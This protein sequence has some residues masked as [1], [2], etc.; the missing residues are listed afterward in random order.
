MKRII[1]FILVLALSCLA[2]ASCELLPEEVLDKLEELGLVSDDTQEPAVDT[3]PAEKPE[4]K[5]EEKPHEHDFVLTAKEDGA[6]CKKKGKE[7]YECS[8]GETKTVTTAAGPHSFM[9]TGDK[10]PSCL[11]QGQRTELCTT[12]GTTNIERYGE[13]TGH[14]VAEFEEYSRMMPCTNAGCSYAIFPEGNGKYSEVIVYK[15]EQV[16]ESIAS[17]AAIYAE[18]DAM[19]KAADKYDPA[20]HAFVQ[21][22]ELYYANQAMEAKYEELYDILVFITGQYQIGQLEYYINLDSASQAN[23]NYVSSARTEMVSKFYSFNGPIAESMFREYYFYGMS[24]EEIDAYVG[25]SDA[26]SNPEYTALV[27]RNDEI[28]SEYL[29]LTDPASSNEVPAMYAEFVANNKRIAEILGY[30]NYLEYAYKEMYSRDYSYTDVKTVYNYVKTYVSPVYNKLYYNFYYYGAYNEVYG[31]G[32]FFEVYDQNKSLNDYIDLLTISGKNTAS[33]S[34]EFNGLMGDG[35]CFR[36][37]KAGTA[38]VTSLYGVDFDG[39]DLP[40]AYFSKGYDNF[41]TI[42]HEFGHYMNE[43]YSEGMYSQSYDLLEMHS[44]GNEMLFLA[45]LNNNP[46]AISSVGLQFLNDYQPLNMFFAIM[47]AIAVDAFEQAVYTDYYDG[48][49]YEAIMDYDATTGLYINADEYDDLFVCILNDLGVD[50]QWQRPGYWRNATLRSPCYYVSYSISALSVLQL[51]PMGTEDFD[52]AADSYLKLFS[53]VDEY[54]NGR[55]YMST[56]EV[57]EYAG[58]STFM[59]EELYQDIY[60]YFMAE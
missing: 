56:V 60:N 35:K 39:S 3:D 58:L 2:F 38:Y 16:E 33:F 42:A 47:N 57:L 8:C 13:P 50:A 1:V 36:N 29:M 52:A 55:G 48:Y 37:G 40:I 28:E 31:D 15:A 53:Y 14:N 10:A 5:P 27:Q 24:D 11:E 7:T 19:I 22:S 9:L 51:L 54:S 26:I 6:N 23:F 32:S 49:G 21:D 17:F 43:V 30:E 18:I 44:Q 12:C 59:E 41:F 4:E 46:G 20:L 34:D 25:E 45:Y